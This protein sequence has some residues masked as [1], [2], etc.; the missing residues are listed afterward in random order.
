MPDR[1]AHCEPAPPTGILAPQ[2][3]VISSLSLAPHQ[4]LKISLF[5]VSLIQFYLNIQLI[6]EAQIAIFGTGA[7]KSTLRRLQMFSQTKWTSHK[8][9]KIL[10]ADF[11]DLEADQLVEATNETLNRINDAV[12]QGE[13][14]ILVLLNLSRTKLY[15]RPPDELASLADLRDKFTILTAI[16]GVEGIPKG[17]INL[18]L[19]DIEFVDTITAGNEWLV[20]QASK[21]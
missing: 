18:I 21:L 15:D 16:I 11:S 3:L 10:Y 1:I 6:I 9:Q 12:L 19:P 14:Y 8:G 7:Y 20:K 2:P 13:P 17:L 4:Y 5:P